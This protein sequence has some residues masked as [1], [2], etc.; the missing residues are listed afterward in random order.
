MTKN[1]NKQQRN[2]NTASGNNPRNRG[3]GRTAT[4]PNVHVQTPEERQAEL[5]RQLGRAVMSQVMD[6]VK[7]SLGETP[8]TADPVKARQDIDTLITDYVATAGSVADVLDTYKLLDLDDD[9]IRTISDFIAKAKHGLEPG[10]GKGFLIEAQDST[11]KIIDDLTQTGRTRI[12]GP[13]GK[14][15]DMELIAVDADTPPAQMTESLVDDL[16][17]RLESKQPFELTGTYSI[18][19]SS[20]VLTNMLYGEVVAESELSSMQAALTKESGIEHAGFD[21]STYTFSRIDGNNPNVAGFPPVYAEMARSVAGAYV[22]E[23]DKEPTFM[24]TVALY[25][26]HRMTQWEVSRQD[27]PVTASAPNKAGKTSPVS[28]APTGGAPEGPPA[29]TADSDA[30]A[31]GEPTPASSKKMPAVKIVAVPSISESTTPAEAPVRALDG[32]P[33]GKKRT[34]QLV[35]MFKQLLSQK[36]AVQEAVEVAAE[37]A[38]G[39]TAKRHEIYKSVIGYFGYGLPRSVVGTGSSEVRSAL[40]ELSGLDSGEDSYGKVEGFKSTLFALSDGAGGHRGGADASRLT[41]EAFLTDVGCTEIEDGIAIER[42]VAEAI[43]TMKQRIAVAREKVSAFN[44]ENDSDS[45]ATAVAAEVIG[46]KL[47]YGSVG[48]S[49]IFIVRNGQ[50][51]LVAGDRGGHGS[52]LYN[53]IGEGKMPA[54]P[55]P[56]HLLKETTLDRLSRDEQAGNPWAKDKVSAYSKYDD[57]GVFELQDGDR[58]VLCSDGIMGDSDQEMLFDAMIVAAVGEADSAEAATKRLINVAKKVDDRSVMIADIKL[59]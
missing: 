31:S 24:S 11:N 9:G 42:A 21:D 40:H 28:A 50:F 6:R 49:S 22:V 13:D 34:A 46:G 58:I 10:E 1:P 12:V 29:A 7:V 20:G 43:G 14:L 38:A 15:Y 23:F 59:Q 27:R 57:I 53:W 5:R 51:I 16:E 19:D 33:E 56:A 30:K 35:D 4:G 32:S 17:Q 45:G 26:N 52:S 8:K 2:N 41:V 47:V 18:G 55:M 37:Q 48:D 44:E 54:E 3:V 36:A 39:E 25:A